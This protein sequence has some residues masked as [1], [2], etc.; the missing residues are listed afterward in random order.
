MKAAVAPAGQLPDQEAVNGSAEQFRAP[1]QLPRLRNILENPANL[2]SAEVGCKRKPGLC[3]IPILPT[4][5]RKLGD[6]R[7]DPRILPYDCVVD[8][9]AGLPVPSDGRFALIGNSDC[10]KIGRPKFGG[11][12]RL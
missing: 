2:Q 5:L 11:L 10:S 4:L 8:R 3:T 6:A 12:H 9:P 1:S 7:R